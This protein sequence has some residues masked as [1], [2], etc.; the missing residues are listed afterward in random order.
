VQLASLRQERFCARCELRLDG[1]VAV[2]EIDNRP[3][4]LRASR[5]GRLAEAL[6]DAASILSLRRG[7]R[8]TR[9]IFLAGADIKE[10]SSG[11]SNKFPP[12]HLQAQWR[13]CRSHRCCGERRR[14]GWWLR[15]RVGLHWRIAAADAKWGCPRSSSDSAGAAHSALHAPGGSGGGA[16][17][18]HIG[19]PIG[20]SRALELGL[21][22]AIADDVMEEAIVFARTTAGD[23]RPLRLASNLN[24]RIAA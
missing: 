2:L 13:L 7:H 20:A 19:N 22:D 17:S 6:K 14:T 11:L 15:D 23:Q 1:N 18:D 4:M 21:I 16:R 9:H 8:G 10:I 5:C 12:P 3:S 24:D